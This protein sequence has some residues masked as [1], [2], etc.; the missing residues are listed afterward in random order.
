MDSTRPGGN[1]RKPPTALLSAVSCCS[2]CLQCPRTPWELHCFVGELLQAVP[3]EGPTEGNTTLIQKWLLG[4]TQAKTGKS[5][6]AWTL[7]L[8]PVVSSDASSA[9]WCYHHLSATIGCG[10]G[11]HH[12][13]T[14][15]HQGGT[16]THLNYCSSRWQQWWSDGSHSPHG[17]RSFGNH[18]IHSTLQ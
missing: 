1:P 11:T 18:Q 9:Q 13:A 16:K 5:G 6:P 3:D 4:G 2:L 8:T 12:N 7:D 17:R 14:T 10:P 15:D